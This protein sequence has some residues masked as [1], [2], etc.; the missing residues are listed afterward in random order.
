MRPTIA[1]MLA[2]YRRHLRLNQTQAGDQ[3]GFNQRL[4]SY[5]ETGERVP[6]VRNFR[7]IATWLG[8]SM[9]ELYEQT[10]AQ[11]TVRWR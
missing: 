11:F 8:M 5:Y 3:I 7:R 10:T 2:D 9:D 6:S 4:Y 1:T